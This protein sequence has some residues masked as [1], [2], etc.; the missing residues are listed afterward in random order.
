V[1]VQQRL[2]VVGRIIDAKV[3]AHIKER[4]PG[5]CVDLHLRGWKTVNEPIQ[6]IVLPDP[7]I[8]KLDVFLRYGR[9]AQEFAGPVVLHHL[10][11]KEKLALALLRRVVTHIIGRVEDTVAEQ[12]GSQGLGLFLSAIFRMTE[13]ELRVVVVVLPL[14]S[15][16]G[17][18][19]EPCGDSQLIS[20]FWTVL[21]S[22]L[23]FSRRTT[24]QFRI[25]G[26]R[27]H[28]RQRIDVEINLVSRFVVVRCSARKVERVHGR[29]GEENGER[30][31][32]MGRE[33]D[34][35]LEI[36]EKDKQQAG[37]PGT[38]GVL[39]SGVAAAGGRRQKCILQVCRV[40]QA[41][42]ALRRRRGAR[43]RTRS[44]GGPGTA[45]ATR[46]QH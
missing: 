25:V 7:V 21:T 41:A 24:Y 34:H 14:Y 28:R 31:D 39:K 15:A 5:L 10:Y 11:L 19:R 30:R 27:K 1:V 44:R 12:D 6:G 26:P 38:E 4:V 9:F 16:Q 23:K 2:L 33:T 22:G 32:S 8:N 18:I 43:D 17:A 37:W 45:D 35:D 42:A 3:E 13:V 29:R 40:A 36:L 46:C 20:D